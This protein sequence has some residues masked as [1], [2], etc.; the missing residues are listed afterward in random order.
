M[1]VWDE[2]GALTRFLR[3]ARVAFARERQ[4]WDGLQIENRDDVEIAVRE[5]QST[6]RVSLEQHLSTIHDQETLHA[7]VLLHSYALAESA[8][9]GLV[10][11]DTRSAGGIE[12]WGSKLLKQRGSDWAEV[13]G[14]KPGAV[15]VHV[16]RNVY[17]HSARTVDADAIERLAQAGHTAWAPGHTLSL[18]YEDLE[19]YRARLRSL[20]RVGGVDPPAKGTLRS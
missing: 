3:S 6:Y 10:G 5:G 8:A 20:L 12:G 18:S 9:C 17:A 1:N 13:K 16:V 14:G 4:I 11:L 19:E 15:E 2:W 7:S